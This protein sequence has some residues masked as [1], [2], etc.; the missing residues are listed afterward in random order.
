[1]RAER[2]LEVSSCKGSFPCPTNLTLPRSTNLV[3]EAC[4]TDSSLSKQALT[5]HMLYGRVLVLQVSEPRQNESLPVCH[6]S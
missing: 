6:Q 2:S 1:M 3:V 4:I 5:C